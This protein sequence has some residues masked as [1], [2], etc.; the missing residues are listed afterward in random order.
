MAKINYSGHITPIPAPAETVLLE[1]MRLAGLASVLI[2]STTRTPKDQARIMFENLERV[3]PHQTRKDIVNAQHALYGPAGDNVIDVYEHC[4]AQGMSSEQVTHEMVRKILDL[5][6]QNIS[7]HCVDPDTSKLSVFDIAPS[8][9]PD[10]KKRQFENLVAAHGNV[11][12][13]LK[14]PTDPA[15]HIQI[16]LDSGEETIIQSA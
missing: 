11:D 5:G 8:S 15:Y 4:K 1:I 2:T 16:M 7:K 13:F 12:K 10:A 6:P 14:P 3:G 9:V